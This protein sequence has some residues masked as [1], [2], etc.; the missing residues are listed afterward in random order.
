MAQNLGRIAQ[1]ALYYRDGPSEA[2]PQEQPAY[3]HRMN[4]PAGIRKTGP[5]TACLSGLIDPPIVN[6]FVLDRQ[7]YLSIFLEK[8]GLI[9]TG[10]GSKRQA[11]LATFLEKTAAGMRHVPLSSRLRMSDRHDRLALAYDTVFC[12]LTVPAPSA[13]K[14]P[15]RFTIIEVS[16]RR[17]E[18]LT[19]TLQLCLKPGKWLETARSRQVV[20]PTRLELGPDEVGGIIRHGGWTL[21]VEESARLVW[22]VYPFNPY[23]NGPETELEYAVGAL[24]VPIRLKP[25]AAAGALPWRRQDVAFE[26]EVNPD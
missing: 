3:V 22:P 6:Q 21:K 8:C 15:L 13:T 9:I 11:E 14:M 17:L 12:E 10:A 16:P 23:S 5:W 18:E 24:S 7:G 4:V 2:I 19:L 20:G 1:N 26:L 25:P